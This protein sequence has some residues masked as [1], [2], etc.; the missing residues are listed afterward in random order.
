MLP[1]AFFVSTGVDAAFAAI[2]ISPNNNNN[3]NSTTGAAATTATV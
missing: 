1:A 3:N 2:Y